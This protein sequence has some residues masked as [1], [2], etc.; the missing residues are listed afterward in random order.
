[1]VASVNRDCLVKISVCG[2]SENRKNF[3]DVKSKDSGD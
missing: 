2:Y 1:M 3:E